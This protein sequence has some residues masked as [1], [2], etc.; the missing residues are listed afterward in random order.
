MSNSPKHRG[1]IQAQGDGLEE[2]EAWATESPPTWQEGL[3]LLSKL[4]N[5]L[6]KRDKIS[7][8]KPFKKAERFIK[9]AGQ[10]GGADALI[11]I[12]FANK[13][14]RKIRVDIEILK[15]KAFISITIFVLFIIIYFL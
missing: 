8:E 5:K 3:S 12:S 14:N 15:G 1:R 13:H 11:K 9:N 2:S 4:K 7:R 10:E 6:S